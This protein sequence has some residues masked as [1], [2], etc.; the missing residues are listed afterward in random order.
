M[1]QLCPVVS[2]MLTLFDGDDD[3]YQRWLVQNP[4]GYV[5]NT[6]RGL[7]SSYMVLHRASC[8]T[9]RSYTPT[10]P[11]GAFTERG[12]VKVCSANLADLRAWL[13]GHGRSDGSFSNECGLCAKA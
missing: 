11:S 10:T 6:R 3:T 13:R 8:R 9:I 1:R 12:Y 7:P 5:I 2:T 4:G